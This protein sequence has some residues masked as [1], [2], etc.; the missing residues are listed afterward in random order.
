MLYAPKASMPREIGGPLIELPVAHGESQ[1]TEI[2]IH[3]KIYDHSQFQT[4]LHCYVPEAEVMA[5]YIP[6]GESHP[7]ERV[8]PIDAEGSFQYLVVPIL[9]A[10]H[11]FETFIKLLHDYKVV[12]VQGGGVWGVGS[13]SLSEV[14]HHP[15]SVRE[16]CLYRFGAMERGLNISILEPKQ[17]KNW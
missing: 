11:D 16:I 10:K 13:Q 7:V 12:I 6:P 14:L 1:E 5:R 17:S 15:S 4:I 9:P 2:S 8:I 3:R